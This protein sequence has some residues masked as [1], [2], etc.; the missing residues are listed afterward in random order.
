MTALLDLRQTSR[1][2]LLVLACSATKRPD[3][4]YMPVRERY[5]GPLWRTLRAA[6]PGG[7]TRKLRRESGAPGFVTR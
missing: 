1:R 2:R 6:D 3:P 4:S 7:S 5:D